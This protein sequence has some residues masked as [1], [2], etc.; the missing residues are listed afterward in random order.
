M[1]ASNDNEVDVA[2]VIAVGMPP[3][4]E[5]VGV[6]AAPEPARAF[7]A[8]CWRGITTGRVVDICV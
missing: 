2:V 7:N 4:R 5:E 3:I 1:V 6:A 8:G